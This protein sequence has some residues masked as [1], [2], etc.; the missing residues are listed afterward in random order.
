MINVT[1]VAKRKK[2]VRKL[3]QGLLVE[4]STEWCELTIVFIEERRKKNYPVKTPR[5]FKEKKKND[6]KRFYL[7]FK[8]HLLIANM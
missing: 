7:V 2:I 4:Q 6:I 1:N 3:I 5:A 8:I